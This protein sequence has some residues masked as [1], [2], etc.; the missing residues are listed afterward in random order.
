MKDPDLLRAVLWASFVFEPLEQTL[1]VSG[2]AERVLELGADWRKV[3]VPAPPRE[4]L[5]AIANG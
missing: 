1:A 3:A 5:V 4:E 2:V